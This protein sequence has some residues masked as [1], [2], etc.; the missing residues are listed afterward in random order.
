[1]Q[2]LFY[3]IGLA[4]IMWELQN[5]LSPVK[6]QA[7]S[8]SIRALKGKP[9]ETWG[10]REKNAALLNFAYLVWT[11]VGLFSSQWILFL[12][13]FLLSLI[14]KRFAVHHAIDAAICLSILVLIILNKYHLHLDIK[15]I[16]LGL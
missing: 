10:D 5:M 9:M 3:F 2:H 13:L 1:M 14:P 8:K 11:M 7:L 12:A 16:L 6:Y 4:P 15:S